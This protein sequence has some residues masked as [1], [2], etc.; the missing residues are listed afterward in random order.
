MSGLSLRRWRDEDAPALVAVADDDALRQYTRVRAPDVEAAL[1]WLAAQ[2]AGWADATR[3]SFAVVDAGG[4]L[5]G[6]VVLKRG[7]ARAAGTA[8]VGYWT[9]APARGRGVASQAVG[10]LT[11]W[12]FGRFAQLHRIELLHAVDNVASCR[13]AVRSGFAYEATLSAQHPYPQQG[14]LHAKERP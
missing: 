6:N 13:V 10:L 5:A 3:F 4:Q 11:A 7:G 8:E 14:H 1:R 9:A 12:A 2:H